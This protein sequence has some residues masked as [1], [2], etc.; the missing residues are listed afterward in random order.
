MDTYQ[1]DLLQYLDTVNWQQYTDYY[2]DCA[3]IPVSL[4]EIVASDDE[5]EEEEKLGAILSNIYHQSMAMPVTEKLIYPL[6]LLTKIKDRGYTA[7]ILDFLLVL[8]TDYLNS[9]GFAGTLPVRVG[10]SDQEDTDQTDKHIYQEITRQT[11][12][13]WAPGVAG[14]TYQVKQFMISCLG[15]HTPIF[16]EVFQYIPETPVSEGNTVIGLGIAAY[17]SGD[18]RYLEK[19]RHCSQYSF[20]ID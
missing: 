20:Y 2:T 4:R 16:N 14:E 12:L 10:F 11:P 5:E 1:K 18:S 15:A 13:L 6:L 7:W 19:S 8:Q 9:I 3:Y 17:L